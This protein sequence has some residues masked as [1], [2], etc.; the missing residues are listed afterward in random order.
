[1][2]NNSNW[3]RRLAYRALLAV[4]TATGVA[5][6]QSA[7]TIEDVVNMALA[8]N[9]RSLKA[10]LRVATAQGQLDRARAAFLPTLTAGGTESVNA[11]A[12]RYGRHF[13]T[14]GTLSVNQPLLN[15][16]AFPLY[17]QAR[18][19]FISEQWGAMEDRRSLAFDAA[20]SFLNALAS[21]RLL[22][23]AQ[24]RLDRAR[25]TQE[26]TQAR[27]DAQLAS[28]ND[29]TRA[30][31]DTS[32]A[33]SQVAQ[34]RGNRER[35][36]FELSFL[37]GRSVTGP[38]VTPERTT[39]AAKHGVFRKED[40]VRFAESRRP[41]LKS[42]EEHS[43]SLRKAAAEPLYRLFPSLGLSGQ[44]RSVVNPLPP[45][46][47]LSESALLTLT[48][49]LYDAGARYADRKTRLAQADSQALDEHQLRRSIATDISVAISALHTARENLQISEQAAV[50]AKRNTEETEI[51]YRQGLARAIELTDAN[52][53]Q[54]AAEV[55]VESAKLDMEQAYLGLRQA[56]GINPV[57]DEL[58]GK[59]PSNGGA[60]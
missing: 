45:D 7:L 19:Q 41:D 10:P 13:A 43:E 21:E 46:T 36:Y 48:W 3:Y 15:L 58:S 35:A 51:L 32:T 1:M 17:A 16:P 52:A 30:T 56:L 11:A 26:D 27:V 38:L 12:D 22:E 20:S 54:Y 55:A 47:S 40:I 37:V 53:S 4:L 25:A 33:E 8:N 6:A 59:A 49:T 39:S 60:Q 50:L 28:T 23:A 18:H 5:S 57:G 9:E 29:A 14:V 42:A 34:A 2:G 31:I 24:R 44:A